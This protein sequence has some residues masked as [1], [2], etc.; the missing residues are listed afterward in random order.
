LK[1]KAPPSFAVF[2]LQWVNN[3][4]SRRTQF[5]PRLPSNLSAPPSPSSLI[6]WNE[7]F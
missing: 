3:D 2:V 7:T 4:S 6:L 5:V 1:Y